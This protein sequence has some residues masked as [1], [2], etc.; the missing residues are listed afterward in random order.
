LRNSWYLEL[1]L[2]LFL[3][4]M[5]LLGDKPRLVLVRKFVLIDTVPWFQVIRL[6]KGDTVESVTKFSIGNRFHAPIQY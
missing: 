6:R 2:I 5:I 4:N 3:S 1:H